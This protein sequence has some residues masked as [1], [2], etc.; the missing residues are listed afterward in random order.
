MH[1]NVRKNDDVRIAIVGI[2]I[3][4]TTMI[5]ENPASTSSRQR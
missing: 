1:R 4:A 2:D 5:A 3:I